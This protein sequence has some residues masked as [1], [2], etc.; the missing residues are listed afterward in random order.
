EDV[1]YRDLDDDGDGIDTPNEDADLDGD[2]T[3]DDTDGDGTPDYLDPNDDD[4]ANITVLKIDDFFDEN[5][6]GLFQEGETID[7]SFIVTNTGT[8]AIGNIT[9]TD[10]LVDVLG[11][12]LAIL[13]PGAIDDTTFR[14]T[15][16]ITQADIDN[17]SF[18]NS[19]T[20]TGVVPDIGP[21]SSL[22]DDPDDPTNRDIDGDGNP[23]DPTVTIFT[24][25]TSIDV[26]DDTAS[27]V[28]DTPVTVDILAN[29]TGIPEDGT[30]TVTDPENGTLVINDGGTPNDPSDDTVT[31][32]PNEGFNGTD[33]FEYTVCDAQENC[34]TATVT[35]TVGTPPML[36]AVDDTAST[37]EDTPTDIDILANDTGIP[38][39]GTLTVTDPENGTLV[40]NDGGTPNDPSDD[41]VTYTPDAGYNGTDTFEYTVCDAQENC[42]TATVTVT[43]GTPPMLDVVDD[44]ASTEEDTP[45]T[46]DIL[47]NDT[48]IPEDGTLTVTDPENGTLVIND[49]GTPN[50][51]SDDTVTYTPNE[52]FNGTDTFEYTVCDAQENCDTATVTVTVGTPPM[53]DA[54]DDIASTDEDTPVDI[55]ILANDSGIPDLDTLSVMQPTNGTVVINDG[56]TPDD[57]NDDTVTYT[58]NEGFNG[59]DTFEYTICDALEN[60]DTATVTIT[61]GTPYAQIDAVDD[62]YSGIFVD[63]TTGGNVPNSNI[64]DNDT[65]EGEALDPEDVI[66][67]ST[68]TEQ[69]TINPDGTIDVAPDTAEGIYTIEYSI[70][71]VANPTNCDTAIVTVQVT[72]AE[73]EA[74][75]VN[76]MVTPNG[77]GRNDFLFIKGVRNAKN[78]SLK[79]F[80]RWGVAVYEGKDYNNQ[81]NVFDGRS[82]GRSTVSAEDYLP[83][84]IYFYIFEYQKDNSKNTTDSGYIYVSK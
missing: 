4:G 20:V 42:D 54:V 84:G 44:T 71:E 51:P 63:G 11:G 21:I 12:P 31:Y 67:T 57:P 73:E 25:D 79:I 48:G 6:D 3:N 10:P 68:P 82:K 61:V 76:Q 27:T 35:V 23:D 15:Y 58:P 5:G 66:L 24:A 74:I 45:V 34:D 75:L 32:T 77:D 56:G 72:I 39:D 52:G 64:F 59:T 60:C 38:E 40:I 22:S 33:T 46:V 83:S 65:L 50:D 16:I 80:N 9:I 49:G 30:L 36:D 55:D 29:D 43:V 81:N 26:V 2:P 69:L 78:N 62:D 19:A 53:L 7:Y 18:S 14:A 17:G 37:D 13:E 41:T 28:E 70:C 8:V 47:A 1:N